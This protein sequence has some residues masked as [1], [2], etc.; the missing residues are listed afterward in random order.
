L[1]PPNK[2]SVYAIIP[3]I[4]QTYYNVEATAI[5]WTSMIY[6]G[7]GRKNFCANF[8]FETTSIFEKKKF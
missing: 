3:E 2:N 8:I 5:T 1:D 7:K 6:M 4:F